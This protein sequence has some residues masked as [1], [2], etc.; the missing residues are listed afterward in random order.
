VGRAYK[1]LLNERMEHGPLPVEEAEAR[2]L[3]WWA[4]QPEA[5]PAGAG[6]GTSPD[7]VDPSPKESK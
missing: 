4:E 6:A 2:L 1:F 3:R 7:A 5:A